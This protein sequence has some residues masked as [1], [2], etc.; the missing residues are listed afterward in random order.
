MERDIEKMFEIVM[1][2][3]GAIEAE[4]EQTQLY[5]ASIGYRPEKY[6]EVAVHIKKSFEESRE[7][8]QDYVEEVIS[9]EGSEN[10]AETV[11]KID[12]ER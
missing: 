6:K 7:M 12:K 1:A 2:K 5:V 3:L 10:I 9:R 8:F 4:I 11:D